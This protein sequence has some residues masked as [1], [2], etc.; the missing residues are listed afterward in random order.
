MYILVDRADICNEKPVVM[1][2]VEL[3][4]QLCLTL[5][6][7]DC[8]LPGSSNHEILQARILEW[9]FP[10]PE[11]LSDSGIEPGSP[12][13]QADSSP[14]ELQGSSDKYYQGNELGNELLV[15]GVR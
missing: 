7:L 5:R 11:D 10:S 6:P 15:L 12:A 13:L 4:T 2:K 9:V 8:S 14:F 3:V 1:D